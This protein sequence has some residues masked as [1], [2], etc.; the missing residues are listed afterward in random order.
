LEEVERQDKMEVI[1]Q[2]LAL[3]QQ[4]V[5]VEVAALVAQ[6]LE[7]VALVVV[8]LDM[9]QL[10]QQ[11]HLDKETQEVELLNMPL[12]VAVVLV[13]LV[14]M[15]ITETQAM[16]AMEVQ[17]LLGSMVLFMLVAVAVVATQPG[18][19]LVAL[20]VAVVA[21]LTLPLEDLGQMV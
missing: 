17:E 16:A 19:A 8:V 13:A 9:A 6:R 4:S 5:A 20:V 2:L 3:P 14:P 12:A 1:H 18:M 7:L 21:V 11:P 15:D 10:E